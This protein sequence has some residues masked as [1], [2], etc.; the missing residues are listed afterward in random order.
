MQ[1]PSQG[2]AA[3]GPRQALG[4]PLLGAATRRAHVQPRLRGE[5]GEGPLPGAHL[6]CPF[7][8]GAQGGVPA[9]LWDPQ[10]GAQAPC[11]G[12]LPA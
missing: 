2:Q 12:D 3:L 11:P 1:Q 9:A 5:G 6:F 4:P 8:P 10:P 7:L